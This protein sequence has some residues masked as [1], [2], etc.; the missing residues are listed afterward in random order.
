MVGPFQ[1]VEAAA[2]PGSALRGAIVEIA[3]ISVNPELPSGSTIQEIHSLASC[4]SSQFV[5]T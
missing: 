4:S 3:R 1:S 2:D 5:F